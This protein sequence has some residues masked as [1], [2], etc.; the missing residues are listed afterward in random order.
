MGK[1][2]FSGPAFGA[3]CLLWSE[4]VPVGSSAATTLTYATRVVPPGE[5]WL[6]CNVSYMCSSCST[7]TA[8]ASSVAAFMIKSQGTTLHGPAF[9]SGTATSTLVTIPTDQGEYQGK[10]VASGSTL[11]FVLAG[12]GSA[13]PMGGARMQLMGYIRFND[14]TSASGTP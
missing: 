7:G 4:Y 11:S 6:L 5:D 12:G 1:T 3:K 13:A 10:L 14:S 8:A 2:A 9:V